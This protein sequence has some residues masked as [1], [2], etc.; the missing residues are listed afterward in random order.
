MGYSADRLFS[1]E[2]A[3]FDEIRKRPSMFLVENSLASISAYHSGFMT[4]AKLARQ[5]IPV[6]LPAFDEFNDWLARRLKSRSSV[7]GW[8][9]MIQ[10]RA[11]DN[12]A[13]VA[14]FFQLL[15]EFRQRS[16][17]L[18]SPPDQA[19]PNICILSYGAELVYYVYEVRRENI[20]KFKF[21]ADSWADVELRL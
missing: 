15:D 18:I 13:A 19:A 3:I 12:A 4:A 16:Y 21:C 6:H 2:Y 7:P 10:E 11:V 1:S 8:C 5:L 17:Q 14:D 20:W 9:R